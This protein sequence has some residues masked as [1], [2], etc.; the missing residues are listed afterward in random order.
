MYVQR[1]DDTD[2]EPNLRTRFEDRWIGLNTTR[3]E[4]EEAR[5]PLSIVKFTD[6]KRVRPSRAKND[7]LPHSCPVPR[8]VYRRVL[9]VACRYTRR[10]MLLLSIFSRPY[11]QVW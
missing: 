4:L 11:Q 7:E 6:R 3:A 1:V 2:T 8:L 9:L 5:L 10:G